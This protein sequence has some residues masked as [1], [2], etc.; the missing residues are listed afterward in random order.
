MIPMAFAAAL[1]E[2]VEIVALVS[3]V[4]LVLS[5]ISAAIH[6]VIHPDRGLHDR[7]AG[8]WVVRRQASAHRGIF[9]THPWKQ[10][11]TG[12]RTEPSG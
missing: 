6:A 3:A 9:G 5:W 10:V 12:L 11:I 2:S 1:T 8:T 4:V 7:L